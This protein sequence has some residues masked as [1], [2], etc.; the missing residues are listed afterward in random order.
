ML[1]YSVGTIHRCIDH[2]DTCHAIRIAIQFAS[3]AIQ[4]FYFIFYFYILHTSRHR[5]S[6]PVIVFLACDF[7]GPGTNLIGP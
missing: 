1:R 2:R 6:I 7:R 5:D 3:I 4:F